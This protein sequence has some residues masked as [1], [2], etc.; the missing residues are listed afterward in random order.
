MPNSH[1]Q[2]ERGEEVCRPQR[3]GEAAFKLSLRV[4][5]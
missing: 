1:H 5:R 2:R 3:G 4:S